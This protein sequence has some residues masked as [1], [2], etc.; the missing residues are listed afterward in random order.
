MLLPLMLLLLMLI[1]IVL[2]LVLLMFKLLYPGTTQ[3]QSV[4]SL[5]T[6]VVVSA[7]SRALTESIAGK[8]LRCP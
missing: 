1:L 5:D 6:A 2:L 7:A 8:R 4:S 3:L